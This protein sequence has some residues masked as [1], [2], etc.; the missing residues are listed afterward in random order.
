MRQTAPWPDYAGNPVKE[1]DRMVHASGDSGIVVV[2]AGGCDDPACWC[3]DYG[4][5]NLRSLALEVGAD[6]RA[7]VIDETGKD[8]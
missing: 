2:T 3:V 6:G 1:G 7:V 8:L 4:H 5:G